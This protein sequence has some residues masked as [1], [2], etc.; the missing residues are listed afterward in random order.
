MFFVSGAY[1]ARTHHLISYINIDF[2]VDIFLSFFE[3]AMF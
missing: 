1:I 2:I 3:I